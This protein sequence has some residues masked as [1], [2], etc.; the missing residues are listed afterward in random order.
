MKCIT[1]TKKILKIK[2]LIQLYLLSSR[3]REIKNRKFFVNLIKK[4][5]TQKPVN[6]QFV[7]AQKTFIIKTKK[8]RKIKIY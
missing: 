2:N 8:E 4:I 3:G 5:Q 7:D 6:F 1:N